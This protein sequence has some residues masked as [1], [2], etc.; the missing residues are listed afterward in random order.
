M[1]GDTALREV[2][3]TDLLGAVSGTDLTSS[4]LRFRIMTLLLLQVIE[5][6]FQ[7]GKSLCLILKL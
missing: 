4:H 6:C 2:V 7:K 3:G 1:I 5:L